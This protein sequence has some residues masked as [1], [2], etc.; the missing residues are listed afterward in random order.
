MT[1]LK[2]TFYSI[3]SDPTYIRIAI[4][5]LTLSLLIAALIVPHGVVLAEHDPGGGG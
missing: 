1:R 4:L 3:A 5:A 2:A